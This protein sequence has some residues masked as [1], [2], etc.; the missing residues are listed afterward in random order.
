MERRWNTIDTDAV[1][2]AYPLLTGERVA[3]LH[4]RGLRVFAWTVDDLPTMRSLLEMGVDGLI[5]NR[6]DLLAA[7][8]ESR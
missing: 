4:G 2:F 7:L 3:S 5:S 8:S 1:T 6:A